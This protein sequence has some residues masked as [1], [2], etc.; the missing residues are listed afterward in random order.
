[1]RKLGCVLMIFL[2]LLTGCGGKGLDEA[3]QAA[4]D[5]RARYLSAAGF[6]ATLDITADYGQ[7]V[8]D[9]VLALEHTAGE[10]SVLTVMEPELL[11]GVTARLKDGESLLEFDGV[12][13]ETG[14]L[15][16][17][18]LSPMD[19]VPWLLEEIQGGFLSTWGLEDLG[20]R[21]CVRVTTSDPALPLGSGQEASLWFDRES[22]AWVRGEISVDG[23]MVLACQVSDFTWKEREAEHGADEQDLG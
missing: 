9:C 4:L 8:F 7:R 23:A 6:T 5:I 2:L 17:T 11:S 1:M 19:C 3:E 21:A 20:E 18:G 15:S 14:A 12:R 16:G 10:E 22:F 13:L